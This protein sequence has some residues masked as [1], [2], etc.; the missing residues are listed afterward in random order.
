[1]WPLSS[2]EF[3]LWRVC[4]FPVPYELPIHAENPVRYNE[5]RHLYGY[6]GKYKGVEVSIQAHGM[7]TGSASLVFEELIML[8]AK[9]IIRLGTAGMLLNLSLTFSS[10]F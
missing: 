7:G 8:G 9:T 5:Y 4:I 3:T 2:H 10:P 1:M 6:T